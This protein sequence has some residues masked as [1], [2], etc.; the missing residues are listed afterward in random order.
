MNISHEYYTTLR[1]I[2]RLMSETRNQQDSGVR[3]KANII[4]GKLSS[5]H[6]YSIKIW[7][8]CAGVSVQQP[9]AKAQHAP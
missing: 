8:I 1:I 2:C 6:V 3:T 9:L 4:R 7:K 5:K